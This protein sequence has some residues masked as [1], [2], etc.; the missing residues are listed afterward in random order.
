MDEATTIEQKRAGQLHQARAASQSS[1]PIAQAKEA[2]NFGK[3]ISQHWLI[4]LAAAL[5]DLLGM[6]PFIGVV[7]NLIFGL[8]LLLYFGPKRKAGGSELAK[9]G[10]PIIIGS[11][12]DFFTAVLPVNI[13]ATLIRIGLN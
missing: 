6:I 8:I 13:G 5:F 7:F 4:L 1:N 9:I 12:I 3:K 11:I 2:L 10:L